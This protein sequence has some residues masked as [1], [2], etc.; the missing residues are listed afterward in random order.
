MNKHK[1]GFIRGRLRSVKFALKG[2]KLLITTE[3]SIKTQVFFAIL[4][5]IIGFY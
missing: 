3:D 2:V 5:T 1:L 4:I